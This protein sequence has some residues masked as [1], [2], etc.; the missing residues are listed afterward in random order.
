M[1]VGSF[2]VLSHYIWRVLLCGIL[3]CIKTVSSPNRNPK[4]FQP[5]ICIQKQA[6]PPPKKILMKGTLSKYNPRAYFEDLC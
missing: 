5:Q 1:T 2:W 4:K 3:E 6:P